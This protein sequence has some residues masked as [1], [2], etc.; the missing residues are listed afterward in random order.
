MFF[1]HFDFPVHGFKYIVENSREL[2]KK[3]TPSTPIGS[4]YGYLMVGAFYFPLLRQKNISLSFMRRLRIGSA[5]TISNLAI[6]RADKQG[7]E[8][9]VKSPGKLSCI[10]C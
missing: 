6:L 4:R 8:I 3:S 2:P 10:G 5:S 9:I 1:V 7:V